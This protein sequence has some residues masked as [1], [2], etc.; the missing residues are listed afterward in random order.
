MSNDKVRNERVDVRMSGAEREA[1][2]RHAERT[3]EKVSSYLRRR[4]LC[5][6]APQPKVIDDLLREH[7]KQLCGIARNVNQ[8]T[9][10]VHEGSKDLDV[11]EEIRSDIKLLLKSRL[12]I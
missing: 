9:K 7:V 3:G 2:A 10:Y 1:I 4:G 11:L 12:V 8:L 5:D 6:K